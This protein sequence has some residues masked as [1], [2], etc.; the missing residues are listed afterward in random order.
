[1]SYYCCCCCRYYYYNVTLTGVMTTRRGEISVRVCRW[2][3]VVEWLAARFVS[4]TPIPPPRF[5]RLVFAGEEITNT[6]TTPPP[7]PLTEKK[8]YL[9]IMHYTHVPL[10]TLRPFSYKRIRSNGVREKISKHTNSI[11]PAATFDK[12]I[13]INC[14]W[15]ISRPRRYRIFTLGYA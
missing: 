15:I 13:I 9:N 10:F 11:F 14:W 1:M 8:H 3:T 7:S 4:L 6:K 2:V 12:I 5:E